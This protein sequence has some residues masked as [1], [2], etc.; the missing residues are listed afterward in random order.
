MKT[1]WQKQQERNKKER[2]AKLEAKCFKNSR[3]LASVIDEV[4]KINEDK[5][6]GLEKQIQKLNRIHNGVFN[7]DLGEWWS[8]SE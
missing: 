4:K 6:L 7:S 5:E 2:L 3:S 1:E 8:K